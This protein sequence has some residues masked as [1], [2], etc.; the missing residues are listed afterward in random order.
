MTPKI[1]KVVLRSS[2]NQFH[3]GVVPLMASACI[4]V[5]YILNILSNVL[6]SRFLRPDQSPH[7]QLCRHVRKIADTLP[8]STPGITNISTPTRDF[9]LVFIM[10]GNIAKVP[11]GRTHCFVG[12]YS[13]LLEV[14]SSWLLVPHVQLWRKRNAFPSLYFTLSINDCKKSGNSENFH[15]PRNQKWGLNHSY[16]S[17][18]VGLFI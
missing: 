13:W 6:C 5:P 3:L 15:T 18:Q 11:F 4:S 1:H 8:P 14:Y 2:G 12:W 16:F 10:S 9:C 7:C 17:P